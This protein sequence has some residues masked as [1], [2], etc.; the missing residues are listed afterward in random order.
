MAVTPPC[1]HCGGDTVKNGLRPSGV[2]EYLCTECGKYTADFIRPVGRPKTGID[3]AKAADRAARKAAKR[4]ANRA[5][6]RLDD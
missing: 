4:K 5:R 3:P 6:K 2:Q 1:P